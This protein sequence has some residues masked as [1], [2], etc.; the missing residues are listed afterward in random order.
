MLLPSLL[1]LITAIILFGASAYIQDEIEKITFALIAFLFVC[2]SL[3]FA[4]APTE[5]LVLAIF[6]SFILKRQI[7]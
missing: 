4:T 1:A 2:I 3:F 6:T 7:E 5:F